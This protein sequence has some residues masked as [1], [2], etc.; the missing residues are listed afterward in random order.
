MPWFRMLVSGLSTRRSEF[1][2]RSVHVKFVIKNLTMEKGFPP[3]TQFFYSIIA[4]MLYAVF[5]KM[6][7]YQEDK[8]AKRG[9]LPRSNELSETGNVK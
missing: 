5:N 9:S 3:G 8:R 4:S 6:L 7:F 1:D 2:T